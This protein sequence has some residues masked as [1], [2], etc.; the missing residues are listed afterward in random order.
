MRISDALAIK[1][2][3]IEMTKDEVTIIVK[4]R[5]NKHPILHT[6]CLKKSILS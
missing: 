6:I 1:S 3:N 2:C 5:S 4:K